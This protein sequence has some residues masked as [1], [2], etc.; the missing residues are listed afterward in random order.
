M[1]S[2]SRRAQPV[3]RGIL[4]ASIIG[5][6][7]PP[8]C[9]QT[10]SGTA[11]LP[12]ALDGNG[13]VKLPLQLAQNMPGPG[14]ANLPPG[15]APS[16]ST[17]MANTVP[18]PPPPSVPGPPQFNPPAQNQQSSAAQALLSAQEAT[19]GPGTAPQ[20]PAQLQPPPPIPDLSNSSAPSV[21]WPDIGSGTANAETQDSQ[22]TINAK[23]GVNY[24]IPV[25]GLTTNLL[26]TP[27]SNP[28]V[29][30]PQD[31]SLKTSM[32]GHQIFFSIESDHPVGA[33][34]TGSATDPSISL[35]LVPKQI[36]GQTY[37]LAVMG[38]TPQPDPPATSGGG[39][40]GQTAPGALPSSST[41]PAPSAPGAEDSNYVEMIS[42]GLAS[43]A[44]GENP[45]G[46]DQAP[47]SIGPVARGP[48]NLT[49]QSL[50][51]GNG[52][53]IAVFTVN[54]STSDPVTLVE[55]DLWQK[56]VLAVSFFPLTTIEPGQT[57]NAYVVFQNDDHGGFGSV[58]QQ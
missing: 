28:V 41:A 58:W 19:S 33:F 49:G 30:T 27:F 38:Y 24:V 52:D 1:K 29:I 37:Y 23:P 44:R 11:P 51:I 4:L 55:N 31:G 12:P 10:T 21:P 6:L 56:G 26:V 32:R 9:A 34:I 13:N 2:I 20:A 46:Y 35:T 47:L 22:Q 8:A 54:D 50:W 15:F 16:A 3:L 57:T 42:S 53:S 43:L 17:P 48:I 40:G 25:S 36:P 45:D 18:A 14:N 7:P 39:G 5:V